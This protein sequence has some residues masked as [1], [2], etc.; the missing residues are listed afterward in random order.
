LTGPAQLGAAL[1]GADCVAFAPLVWSRL[2]EFVR[3]PSGAEFWRDLGA[4]QRMLGDATRVCHA[5]AITVP[6]L[7]RLGSGVGRSAAATCSEFAGLAE[8]A[9]A[10]ALL[11]RL[12]AIG[13]AGLV[14]QLP[15]LADLARLFPEE[16]DED[17][18]DA[19]NDLVRIGLEAGAQVVVVRASNDGELSGSLE[20]VAPLA[21]YYCSTLLGV[22]GQRASAFNDSCQVAVLDRGGRWPELSS[23]VVLTVGDLTEWWTPDDLRTVLSGRADGG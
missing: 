10:A 22:D 2:P 12:H 7:P 14:A 21:T 15:T 19:L 23:G 9:A 17:R 20:A 8:V 3:S 11:D 6:L 1:K 13:E 16:A 5:D 18:E 4:T